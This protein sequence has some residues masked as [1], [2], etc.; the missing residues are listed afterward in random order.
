M[1]VKIR[2]YSGNAQGGSNG[3]CAVEVAPLCV[4]RGSFGFSEDPDFMDSGLVEPGENYQVCHLVASK[5]DPSLWVAPG[6]RW[7]SRR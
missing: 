6:W 5:E 4:V 2:K 1:T 3:S 7:M